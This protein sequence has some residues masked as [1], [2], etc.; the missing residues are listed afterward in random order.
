M[1]LPSL[2][3]HSG[4]TKKSPHDAGKHRVKESVF[5]VARPISARPLTVVL[6]W[7]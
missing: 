6:S 4:V 2:R 1:E 3:G 7:R 5:P